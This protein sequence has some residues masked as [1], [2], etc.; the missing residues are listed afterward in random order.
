MVAEEGDGEYAHEV[1]IEESNDLPEDEEGDTVS[2][3]CSCCAV[4]LRIAASAFAL[5]DFK[6][7]SRDDRSMDFKRPTPILRTSAAAKRS[8]TSSSSRQEAVSQ[9]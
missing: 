3:S 8:L 7:K 2:L 6:S 1:E 4:M 9:A 5:A